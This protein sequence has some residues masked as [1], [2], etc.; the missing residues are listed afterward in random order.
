MKK[1]GIKRSFIFT[2]IALGLSLVLVWAVYYF[3]TIERIQST[4]TIQ[5]ETILDEI[6][7]RVEE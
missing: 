1:I 3:V 4:Q 7:S 5:T 6:Q 2:L